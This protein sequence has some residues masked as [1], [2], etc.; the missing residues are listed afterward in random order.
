MPRILHVLNH[1]PGG[2]VETMVETMASGLH[3]H[4]YPMEVVTLNNWIN[5]SSVLTKLDIQTRP[6]SKKSW[7][8]VGGLLLPPQIAFRSADDMKLQSE[9]DLIHAHHPL[10]WVVAQRLAAHWRK[11]FVISMHSTDEPWMTSASLPMRI[12]RN[13]IG[14]AMRAAA[15]IMPCSRTGYRQLTDQ[16]G[17]DLPQATVLESCVGGSVWETD[18]LDRRPI[19]IVMTG[20]WASEKNT[21]FALKVLIQ[22]SQK[23]TG[24]RCA[25]LGGGHLRAEM[26]RV[27]M[28]AG[29]PPEIEL[30]GWLDTKEEVLDY[31]GQSKV[32]YLPS[33]FEGL[34]L[35]VIEALVLGTKCVISDIPTHREAFG[36]YSSVTFASPTDLDLNVQALERALDKPKLDRES[37]LRERF[38]SESYIARLAAIY[39]EAVQ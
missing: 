14:D 25:I 37:G 22:L 9:I 35:S 36:N 21:V 2:G 8:R 13:K 11:P 34:P 4:G 5:P 38:S 3:E 10:N 28:E 39:D 31:I 27:V 23:R 15:R 30:V 12:F 29:I 32:L 16:V 18:P 33:L 20:R 26:E 1:W 7:N 19:D 24:L 17:W 6:L